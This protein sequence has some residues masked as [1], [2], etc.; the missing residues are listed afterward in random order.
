MAKKDK[1]LSKD[2]FDWVQDTSGESGK[3]SAGKKKTQSKRQPGAAKTGTKEKRQIFIRYTKENGEI[4]ALQ[5]M[6]EAMHEDMENPWEEV[7]EDQTVAAF[8]LTGDL[9]E[10]RLLEIH[11]NYRV[12]TGG[13][14]PKLISTK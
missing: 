9:R 6:S 5:E 4:V 1:R 10:K 7:P 2:A 11:T 3:K 8:P 14:K 13:K 12:E